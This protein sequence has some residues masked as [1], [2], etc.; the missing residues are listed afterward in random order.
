MIESPNFTQVPNALFDSIMATMNE[1]ELRVFL[2]IVRKT[3]GWSKYRDRIS[4]TQIS[5]MTGLSRSAVI[6]GLYGRQAKAGAPID[7][8]LLPRKFVIVFETPKGNEYMV[9]VMGQQEKS[10]GNDVDQTSQRGGP[11]LGNDVDPQ[12]KLPKETIQKKDSMSILDYLNQ[13]A[14][15]SFKPIDTH[16]KLIQARLKDGFTIEECKRVVDSR[17][18][19]WAN[20]PKMREYLRPSTL[21]APSHFDSYL[22]DYTQPKLSGVNHDPSRPAYEERAM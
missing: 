20:D 19:K 6:N 17:V 12:K 15:K 9:N 13:K 16:L 3:F 4:L 22:N 10:L 7:G 11:V 5:D 1:S 21:F 2:A 18:A 14:G 8:G